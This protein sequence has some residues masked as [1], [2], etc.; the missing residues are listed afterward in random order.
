M[1]QVCDAKDGGGWGGPRTPSS[2]IL[3]RVNL[4]LAEAPE[5][6]IVPNVVFIFVFFF[7]RFTILKLFHNWF[8]QLLCFKHIV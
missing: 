3:H 6:L 5:A 7:N 8:L 4:S 1:S 2:K